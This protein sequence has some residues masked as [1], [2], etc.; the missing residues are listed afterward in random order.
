MLGVRGV[1]G[2][3]GP[4][5][6]VYGPTGPRWTGETGQT[7]ADGPFLWY[8]PGHPLAVT[9]DTGPTGEVGPTGGNYTNPS[10]DFDVTGNTGSTGPINGPTGPTATTPVVTVI[11]LGTSTTYGETIGSTGDYT[12]T[13][14]LGFGPTATPDET[15]VLHGVGIDVQLRASLQGMTAYQNGGL[16]EI[17]MTYTVLGVAG[18]G[19]SFPVIANQIAYYGTYQY[20]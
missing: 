18:R 19:V 14:A 4:G 16:Y 17:K 10:R 3:T 7:G 11:T 8:G 12:T 15:L 20:T 9:G 6:D 13:F 5:A 2:P 1:T